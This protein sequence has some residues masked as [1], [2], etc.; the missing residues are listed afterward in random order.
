M[1]NAF[2]YNANTEGRR[3]WLSPI[4][5]CTSGSHIKA[6]TAVPTG[7]SSAGKAER[8]KTHGA[9]WPASLAEGAS[10]RFSERPHVSNKKG[11]HQRDG[12]S[13]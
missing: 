9:H 11:V 2:L 10:Y 6:G 7:N 8:Q 3:R 12:T 13:F 4:Q 1:Q 5:R